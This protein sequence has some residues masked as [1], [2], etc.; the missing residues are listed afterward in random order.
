[1]TAPVAK[2]PGTPAVKADL[3]PMT[4]SGTASAETSA[5]PDPNAQKEDKAR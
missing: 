5:Q 4:A 1:M 3:P 2:D